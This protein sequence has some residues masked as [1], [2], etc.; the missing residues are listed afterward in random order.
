[1]SC[2]HACLLVSVPTVEGDRD[3]PKAEICDLSAQ[4]PFAGCQ[5]WV[6]NPH[7][8]TKVTGKRIG[9]KDK[10][11]LACPGPIVLFNV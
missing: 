4:P 9:V 7:F 1:M 3:P 11:G 5:V 8:I 10:V 6:E 2:V